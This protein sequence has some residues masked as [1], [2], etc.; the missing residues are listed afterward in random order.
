MNKDGGCKWGAATERLKNPP[1]KSSRKNQDRGRKGKED[2]MTSQT[3]DEEK[4]SGR[5]WG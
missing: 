4:E 1:E 5:N 3:N 2:T